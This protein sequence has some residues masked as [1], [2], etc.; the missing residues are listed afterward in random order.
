MVTEFVAMTLF[1]VEEK[2]EI[3]RCRPSALP[4]VRLPRDEQRCR[5]RVYDYQN[6]MACLTISIPNSSALH[7]LR[8]LRDRHLLA[9]TELCPQPVIPLLKSVALQRG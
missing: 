5:K 3:R 2:A 8:L 1:T 6:P 7:T 9:G 4:V